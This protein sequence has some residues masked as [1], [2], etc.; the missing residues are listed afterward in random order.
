MG[1]A[2]GMQW[3]AG[4]TL[5]NGIKK[6]SLGNSQIRESIAPN[7]TFMDSEPPEFTSKRVDRTPH[8]DKNASDYSFPQT[9]E[10]FPLLP[11]VKFPVMKT[12]IWIWGVT[13]LN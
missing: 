5:E 11:S 2:T 7:H 9:A 6:C 4:K 8:L 13:I 3:Y 10:S 12:V 1:H